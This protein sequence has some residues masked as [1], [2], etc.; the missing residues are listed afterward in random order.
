MP[1][2]PFAKYKKANPF[3][4]YTT[5]GTGPKPPTGYAKPGEAAPLVAIPGGPDSP[6]HAA[7]VERARS[8]AGVAAAIAEARAKAAIELETARRKQDMAAGGVQIN[9][10]LDKLT[11]ADFLK[12]LPPQTAS[13]VQA[14]VDGRMA[15]PAGAA[16]KSPYWQQMLANVAHADPNFDAVN[17]NARSHTRVDFTSGQSARNIKALN[18]A[19]GHLGH[20]NEQLAGTASH[21]G[22]PFATTVNQ[23][24]NAFARGSGKSGPTLFDQTSGALASEL[25]QVFRGSGGAEADVKRYLEE[26]SPNASMEQKQA[27]VK[28]IAGLLQS[29]LEA[30]GDQYKQ[31][32]GKTI[33]PLQLLNPHAQ[34]AFSAILGADG[35]GGDGGPPATGTGGGNPPGPFDGPSSTPVG[36]AT[37]AQRTESYPAASA[38]LDKMIR[39]GASAADINAAL[40]KDVS[41]PVTQDQVSAAQS[42]LR[43][44]PH[45]AGSIGQAFRIAQN[46]PLTRLS[47]T[48]G[49]TGITQAANALTAGYLDEGAGLVNHL[50]TGQ[51]LN[52]AI[53]AADMAKQAQ[54]NQNPKA[55]L[56]GNVVGGGLAMYGG[57]A[58]LDGL[59]MAGTA[60]RYLG[61]LAPAVGDAAYGALY[62]SGENNDN[63][64]AGAGAGAAGSVIGGYVGNKAAGMFG[65][66]L[67]GVKNAAVDYL[68]ANGVPLTSGQILG[69]NWKALEDKATSLP[70][71]GDMIKNRRSEGYNAF[72]QAAFNQGGAPIGATPNTVGQSGLDLLDQATSDAYKKT[73]SGVQ[74]NGNDPQFLND[75]SGIVSQGKALPDPMAG[76][77]DYTLRTRVGQ[78]FDNAG[79]L[80]GNDFQQSIRGLRR[81]TRAVEHLPYG[82]DFG[83][84]TGGAENAMKGLLDRQAPGVVPDYLKANAAYRNQMILEDALKAGK[85]QIDE[86]GNPIFT[87]SQL[88]TASVRNGGMAFSRPFRQLAEA[89]QQVLPSKIPDSGT[90][91]RAAIGLLA[92]TAGGGG[93]G[94]V[95]GTP[96][97]ESGTGGL[98]GAGIGLATGLL[99]TKAGQRA[100]TA[101]LLRRP[102]IFKQGGNYIADNSDRLSQLL[103]GPALGAQFA[104][105]GQ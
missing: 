103:G 30:V 42:W 62:G 91:G 96:F 35:S 102:A 78:S 14:L 94:A 31:G 60:S 21:G 6:E 83:Q 52:E 86:A 39:Q 46:S 22:F 47:A 99:Y 90:A 9:P 28:N 37:G 2:N 67:R 8:M 65:R 101:A 41:G 59:G 68:D 66:G 82:Y 100:L 55:A 72:N 76:N 5:P 45:Y 18:T 49:A 48:P 64:L 97:G 19:I 20:L 15:F 58:L 17:Y 54:A 57:G 61:K 33:D 34:K 73:L 50:A 40:P 4:V 12:A 88:N 98:G 92:A 70:L 32:M 25:T 63:R 13:T 104:L 53:A 1:E 75:M 80:S 87:P 85:N 43:N 56:A 38:I 84:V 71:V 27:A 79:N 95:A 10:A 16:M 36:V 23:V 44:N 24:E 105:S 69:G 74:V 26:L 89:G 11:G 81:D 51:P 7:A 77:A 29:R 93:T 3:A